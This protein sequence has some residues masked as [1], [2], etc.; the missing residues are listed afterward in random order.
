MKR[1]E[2]RL[3][4]NS[5]DFKVNREH[6]QRLA[7]N[8]HRLQDEVRHNR[9]ARDIERLARQNKLSVRE[10]LKP[11]RVFLRYSIREILL[12]R[13]HRGVQTIGQNMVSGGAGRA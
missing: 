5:A 11:P 2:S 7:E 10:R 8:L 1:I 9:P 4:T 13:R 12:A 6:N 3:N